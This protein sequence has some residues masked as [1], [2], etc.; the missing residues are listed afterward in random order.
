ME[1][2]LSQFIESNQLDMDLDGA[3]RFVQHQVME[4]ARDCLTKSV[5]KHISVNY[6]CELSDN[7]KQLLHDVS[8]LFLSTGTL[9]SQIQLKVAIRVLIPAYKKPFNFKNWSKFR[10]FDTVE[11]LEG[12]PYCM[13]A[14]SVSPP[15]YQPW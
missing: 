4:L 3:A 14:C 1:E 8:Y 11:R 9:N 10:C 13:F 5:S 2:R 15:K 7:L 6:F 12:H